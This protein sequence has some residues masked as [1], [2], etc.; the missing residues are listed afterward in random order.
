MLQRVLAGLGAAVACAALVAAQPARPPISAADL[1]ALQRRPSRGA[2]I[3]VAPEQNLSYIA[4]LQPPVA[5]IVDLQRDNLRLHLLYKAIIE[6]S[7]SRADFLSRV[8]CRIRPH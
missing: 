1:P 3:G 2:Y 5:F 7:N 6:L 4:A 8:F